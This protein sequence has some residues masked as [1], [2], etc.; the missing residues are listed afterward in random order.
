M[1]QALG[2]IS[3]IC[4]LVI[5]GMEANA[6]LRALENRNTGESYWEYVPANLTVLRSFPRSIFW[7]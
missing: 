6:S 4:Q 7:N 5:D 2:V 1:A 3:W